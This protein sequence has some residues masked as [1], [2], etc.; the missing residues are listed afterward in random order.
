M[1]YGRLFMWKGFSTMSE[2]E[3]FHLKI[4][5]DKPTCILWLNIFPQAIRKDIFKFIYI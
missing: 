2:T 4:I 1:I 3:S 5:K